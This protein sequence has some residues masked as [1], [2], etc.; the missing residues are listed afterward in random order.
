MQ[1]VLLPRRCGSRVE[2][3]DLQQAKAGISRETWTLQPTPMGSFVLVWFEGDVE[4]AFADLATD[5]DEF[6]TW[7]RAQAKDPM[8]VDLA[9]PDDGPPPGLLTDWSA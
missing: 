7:F 5:T 9:V 1:L 8:G 3:F 6:S 2:Q 4:K